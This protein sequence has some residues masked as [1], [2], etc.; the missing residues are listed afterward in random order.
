[1]TKE[2]YIRILKDRNEIRPFRTRL[3]EIIKEVLQEV[4][5]IA[6]PE[7]IRIILD[8]HDVKK[9]WIRDAIY[10][11][12]INNGIDFVYLREC[13]VK[14]VLEIWLIEK[15][16]LRLVSEGQEQSEQSEQPEQEETEHPDEQPAAFPVF[17]SPSVRESA[18]EQISRLR[19]F[20]IADENNKKAQDSNM[21]ISI[22]ESRQLTL[23]YQADSF[24]SMET[25]INLITH[26]SWR[27]DEQ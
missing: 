14:P 15:P 21:V 3:V 2:D 11:L 10:W 27:A 4:G 1:M 24:E 7:L 26:R 8:R 5:R 19:C 22:T 20:L 9:Y 23:T 25:F 12:I 17:L 6:I 18:K 16:Q 13:F